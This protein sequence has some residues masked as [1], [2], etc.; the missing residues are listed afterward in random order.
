MIVY[1]HDIVVCQALSVRPSVRPSVC[2][3]ALRVSVGG[4]VSRI[5]T[6]FT[7]LRLV[8]VMVA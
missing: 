3:V 8:L 5:G 4:Y 7:A 1:W 6:R 2:F